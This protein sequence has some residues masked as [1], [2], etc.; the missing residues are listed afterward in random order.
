MTGCRPSQISA[1]ASGAASPRRRGRGF[2]AV[3]LWLAHT[4]PDLV[5]SMVVI[6][7]AFHHSGLRDD[8]IDES[9]PETAAMM[10]TP[11]AAKEKA[12]YTAEPTFTVDDVRAMS[13]PTLLVYADDDCIHL[14]HSIELYDALPNAQ[15]AIVPGASHLVVVEQPGV[16]GS[17]VEDFIT[18]NG[19]AHTMLPLRRRGR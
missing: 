12:M 16:I 10:S 6:G 9:D 5:R 4:R 1:A 19:E 2:F 3:A 15:P 7:A 18:S 17:L 13:M 11:Y 8:W 14:A